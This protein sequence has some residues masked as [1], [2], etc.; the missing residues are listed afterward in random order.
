MAEVG[1][2]ERHDGAA[3]R[4][5]TLTRVVIPV[6]EGADPGARDL[7]RFLGI[8]AAARDLGP[9]G[10]GRLDVRKELLDLVEAPCRKERGRTET[11]E[12]ERRAFEPLGGLDV[13]E[14]LRRERGG[15]GL[16]T[17]HRC[18]DERAVCELHCR[19]SV[20]VDV[21]LEPAGERTSQERP[22]ALGNPDAPRD[23]DAAHRGS[24]EECADVGSPPKD[25]HEQTD[26]RGRDREH[27][28]EPQEFLRLM[29][30]RARP[31]RYDESESEAGSHEPKARE[32][33]ERE[34]GRFRVRENSELRSDRGERG[35]EARAEPRDDCDHAMEPL[36]DGVEPAERR[37]RKRAPGEH[38]RE[39]LERR[40]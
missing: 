12:L 26:E 19:R 20:D 39:D 35:E 27:D 9:P 3:V 18:R 29:R 13:R 37:A 17:D 8:A 14:G 22:R 15:F 28:E 21:R 33:S 32:G 34:G 2:R 23:D 24:A 1:E 5:G 36:G 31:A 16:V 11:L 38:E 7:D 30:L 6:S 4:A 10:R 25:D 40:A